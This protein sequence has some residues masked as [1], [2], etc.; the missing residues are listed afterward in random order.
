MDNI[1]GHKK[2]LSFFE[3]LIK[4]NNLSHAY[5]FSGPEHVGKKTVAEYLA[6][7]I[8]SVPREKLNSEA[9]YF[10]INKEKNSKTK[11]TNKDI[12]VIQIRKLKSFLIQSSFK[13][14]NYKVVIIDN[15]E[16]L[17]KSASNSLLKIL[18]EPNKKIVFFLISQNDDLI[19]ETI[20]SRCQTIYFSL[21][22]EEDLKD[23][24]S[25]DL[26]KNYS[27][28]VAELFLQKDDEEKRDF[29]KKE[30]QRFRDLFDNSFAQKL[31]LIE[32]LFGDK[33]DHILARENISQVLKI[34]FMELHHLI[35]EK[36]FL[37]KYKIENILK[38]EK[39]I[40][41]A[42]KLIGQN[43]HPRLLLENIILEIP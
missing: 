22:K 38:I 6:S 21:V 36:D 3:K 10:Y 32:D 12:N 37:K 34:W 2:I 7:L 4:E 1:L 29:Y 17:N 41:S 43:V 19:L 35:N 27:G 15:A 25:A 8:F 11:K 30:K 9:D 42:R 18:E 39:E 40:K 28:L 23:N 33:T 14:D 31:Q 26:L 20:K 13:K 16:F 24:F 5:L